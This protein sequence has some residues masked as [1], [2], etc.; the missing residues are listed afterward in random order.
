MVDPL[1]SKKAGTWGSISKIH[2]DMAALQVDLP[3]A[4]HLE[5]SPGQSFTWRWSLDPSDRYTVSSLRKKL[6]SS[7]LH[8]G[9]NFKTN[10]LKI[11]PS[12]VNIAVWKIQHKRLPTF[13]NLA[14]RGI[15]SEVKSCPLCSLEPETED[16]LM[17]GCPFSQCLLREI[18]G[19]WSLNIPVGPIESLLNWGVNANFKGTKLEAFTSIIYTFCWLIWKARNQVVHGGERDSIQRSL[20]LLQGLPY[21]WFFHRGG[22]KF[23]FSWH[24]WCCFPHSIFPL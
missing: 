19:W 21:F 17:M 2:K 20:S 1:S 4:F 9:L 7:F 16:H 15:I 3:A 12:K 13:G 10:W 5:S 23:K 18:G 14:R 22:C 24:S 11:V 6:D 8:N